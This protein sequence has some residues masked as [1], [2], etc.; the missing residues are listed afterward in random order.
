MEQ[1]ITVQV[2]QGLQKLTNRMN[3]L[4]ESHELLHD[5]ES[6]KKKLNKGKGRL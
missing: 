2:L 5:K 4:E 6:F 1:E 3:Y